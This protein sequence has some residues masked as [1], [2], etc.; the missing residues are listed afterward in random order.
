MSASRVRTMCRNG[1]TSGLFTPFSSNS[2]E[3]MECSPAACVNEQSGLMIPLIYQL[4]YSGHAERD[5]TVEHTQSV[6]EPT[7]RSVPNANE[8]ADPSSPTN[9]KEQRFHREQVSM[10]DP[11]PAIRQ[12]TSYCRALAGGQRS[13]G[14]E[15][16]SLKYV[17]GRH[18]SACKPTRK[19][20]RNLGPSQAFQRLLDT[21][22]YFDDEP[23]SSSITEE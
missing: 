21:M 5:S 9:N 6:T 11:D 14:A 7:D 19:R 16:S 4:S 20:H 15:Q 2:L 8:I 3:G 1:V 12:G 10:R 13:V 23:T 22:N 18:F 17:A